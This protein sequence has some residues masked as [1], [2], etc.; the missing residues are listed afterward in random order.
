MFCSVLFCSVLFCSVLFYSILFCSILFC[1]ILFC[2]VLFCSVLFC[3]GLFCSILFCSVLFCSVL[4]Y[5]ILFYSILFCSV[6]FCSVLFCSIL[7]CSMLFFHVASS[8]VQRLPIIHLYTV[9]PYNLP[10][11]FNVDLSLMS[12]IHV[13]EGFPFNFLPPLNP[14]MMLT[15]NFNLDSYKRSKDCHLL[16]ASPPIA[17]SSQP[18]VSSENI[19]VLF[20]FSILFPVCIRIFCVKCAKIYLL[21]CSN[22][23][24]FDF[25]VCSVHGCFSTTINLVLLHSTPCQKQR[26]QYKR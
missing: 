10:I 26:H 6:L 23:T 24:P 5:S 12:T 18:Y 25:I 20:L 7:F 16:P 15:K 19:Y 8:S 13:L 14:S 4:F 9:P 3:S 2:S 22:A 11:F 1:S 17:R 21:S